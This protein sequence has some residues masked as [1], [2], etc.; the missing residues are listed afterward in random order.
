M[1]ITKQN[2]RHTVT[3]KVRYGRISCSSENLQHAMATVFNI[4]KR[5]QA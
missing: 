5:L 1:T 3:A 4:I 2:N